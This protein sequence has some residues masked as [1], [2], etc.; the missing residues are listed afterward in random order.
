MAKKKKSTEK[1][2]KEQYWKMGVSTSIGR[3]NA[4]DVVISAHR[5]LFEN[6]LLDIN[7]YIK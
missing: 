5:E 2:S 3:I 1:A 4:G 6:S 7:D